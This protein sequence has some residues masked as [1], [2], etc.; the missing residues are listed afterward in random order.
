MNFL[1]TTRFFE[2]VLQDIKNDKG[3]IR[4]VKNSNT[5]KPTREM[6]EKGGL[7]KFI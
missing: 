2:S 6:K 5:K 1:V 4:E 7:V 3:E